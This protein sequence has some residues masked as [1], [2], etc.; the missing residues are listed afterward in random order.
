M[1]NKI[2]T[3]L[4]FHQRLILSI[5]TEISPI[6]RVTF[7]EVVG[8]AC[9]LLVCA[10]RICTRALM[11]AC[12]ISYVFIMFAAMLIPF[13]LEYF[14]ILIFVFSS[15]LMYAHRFLVSLALTYCCIRQVTAVLASTCTMAEGDTQCT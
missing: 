15:S 9:K 7:Q 6:V 1:Y 3:G 11:I 8:G 4:N 10:M 14:P 13:L 12:Y 5:G 2:F